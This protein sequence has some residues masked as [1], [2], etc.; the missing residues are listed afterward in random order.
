MARRPKAIPRYDMRVFAHDP[1]VYQIHDHRGAATIDGGDV[2]DKEGTT[3]VHTDGA[4]L[5]PPPV[6]GANDI[7]NFN[8]SDDHSNSNNRNN[9]RTRAG[10]VAVFPGSG[11]TAGVRIPSGPHSST[12][13]EVAGFLLAASCCPRGTKMT[14]YT[15]SQVAIHQA[16]TQLAPAEAMTRNPAPGGAFVR[17]LVG[18]PFGDARKKRVRRTSCQGTRPQRRKR[19]RGRRQGGRPCRT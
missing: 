14:V 10:A 19:Q 11:L 12:R 4:F 5:L 6:P 8:N 18:T 2:D 17:S 7:N 9:S 15:D 16:R 1:I 3:E 13:A